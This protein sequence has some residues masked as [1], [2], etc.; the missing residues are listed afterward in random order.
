MAVTVCC[1][2]NYHPEDAQAEFV[3]QLLDSETVATRTNEA[4]FLR[5]QAGF[6]PGTLSMLPSTCLVDL[7]VNNRGT[8]LSRASMSLCVARR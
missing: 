7:P 1:G 8:S 6:I 5:D 2:G 4:D 3:H